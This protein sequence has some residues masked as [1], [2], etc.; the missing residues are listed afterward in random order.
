MATEQRLPT[1]S[2]ARRKALRE[3]YKLQQQG[4]GVSQ[5]QQQQQSTPPP[6][7]D[8]ASA[9]VPESDIDVKEELDSEQ[10]VKGL[11]RGND[12]KQLLKRENALISELRTLDSEQKGLVY[13]NYNKLISASTTLQTI[14]SKHSS[15]SDIDE[16]KTRMT[17][18]SSIIK[19]LNNTNETTNLS[20]DDH[21]NAQLKHAAQW[22]LT[23]E[24]SLNVL[25]NQNRVDEAQ[26]QG[27]KAVQMMD[28]WLNASS[29][30]LKELSVIRE[31]CSAILGVL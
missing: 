13:N 30:E 7:F 1:E 21:H 10:Y 3:F 29:K 28:S 4:A 24:K 23:V 17:N 27:R 18:I 5:G 6:D 2:S 15:L 14:S 8:L 31:R 20:S 26:K 22:L 12:I 25:K 11:V 19:S 9:G 16:L